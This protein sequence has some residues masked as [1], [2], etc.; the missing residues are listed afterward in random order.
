MVLSRLLCRRAH[1][2]GRKDHS[3]NRNHSQSH[4]HNHGHNH[5]PRPRRTMGRFRPCHRPGTIQR[6]LE[7][8]VVAEAQCPSVLCPLPDAAGQTKAQPVVRPLC[9]I[10]QLNHLLMEQVVPQLAA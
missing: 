5:D 9:Q 6:Q 2:E 4:D 7:Q 8:V 10:G 3:R 1:Q